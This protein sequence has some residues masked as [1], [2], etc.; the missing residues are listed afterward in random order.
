VELLS[1]GCILLLDHGE[2]ALR[3]LN[4]SFSAL[5]AVDYL[6]VETQAADPLPV[7][8]TFLEVSCVTAP[9]LDSIIT[10]DRCRDILMPS[11]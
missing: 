2:A 11:W 9:D 7:A 5:T 4:G 6:V 8:M 10:L 1:N 3:P